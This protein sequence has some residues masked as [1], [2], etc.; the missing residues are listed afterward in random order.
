MP[1]IES[2]NIS[3]SRNGKEIR[4]TF[5]AHSN[6][7]SFGRKEVQ[8]TK[9]I[10]KLK[11]PEETMMINHD[12]NG[13]KFSLA[14]KGKIYYP[15]P[16]LILSPRIG[17]ILLSWPRKLK[18][19]HSFEI[20]HGHYYANINVQYIF[21]TLLISCMQCA[22][23]VVVIAIGIQLEIKVGWWKEDYVFTAQFC[24][25]CCCCSSSS[26]SIANS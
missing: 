6:R 24:C 20:E 11:T 15:P 12:G 4:L 13:R 26:F 23:L 1:S 2:S 19:I 5:A 16:P 14:E 8:R 10:L 25:F 7:I 18:E 22:F 9:V 21:D 3:S 17:W